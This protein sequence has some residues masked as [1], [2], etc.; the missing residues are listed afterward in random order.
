MT[1]SC[2]AALCI[3]SNS[4]ICFL[5]V[6]A[7]WKSTANNIPTQRPLVFMAVGVIILYKSV[8][9]A[10]CPAEHTES[11]GLMLSKV[12]ILSGCVW[13]WL[14]FL[15][16]RVALS[17]HSLYPFN[18]NCSGSCSLLEILNSVSRYKQD[19]RRCS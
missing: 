9:Y 3:W 10:R 19:V 17:Y 7:K 6:S 2:G 8:K 4:P 13:S 18:T 11:P 15:R 14:P 1:K 16:H 12:F 5:T